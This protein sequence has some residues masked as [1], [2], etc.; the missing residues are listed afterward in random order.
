MLLLGQAVWAQDG[1]PPARTRAV[2]PELV[3]TQADA[4]GTADNSVLML[5]A[6]DFVPLGTP[7]GY[8][9]NTD[10]AL[11]N[12]SDFYQFV[13]AIHLP[14]GALITNV[15]LAG[16]DSFVADDL[17]VV[18]LRRSDVDPANVSSDTMAT[19]YSSG[20]GGC[21]FWEDNTVSFSTVNNDVYR[22]IVAVTFGNSFHY[23]TDLTLRAVR[24]YWKRQVT[25]LDGVANFTDVPLGNPYRQFVEAATAS[26][27]MN[28][29]T[30]GLFCPDNPVTR[31]QLALALAKALGLR[32]VN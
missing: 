26:G 14:T 28:A 8:Y 22:Y 23:T 6:P 7:V 9:F 32:W 27:I 18:V 12:T 25:P 16:C 4:F 20:S 29:C 15:E 30:T 1:E 31:A 2:R 5:N 17:S 24:I 3:S 21:S 11:V 13:A 19:V 10:G